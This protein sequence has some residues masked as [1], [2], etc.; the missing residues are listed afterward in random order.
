MF[1]DVQLQFLLGGTDVTPTGWAK[2]TMQSGDGGGTRQ[3]RLDN[4]RMANSASMSI[5]KG[6]K[7]KLEWMG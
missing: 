4:Q 2:G 5:M 3:T 6:H 7:E 1:D